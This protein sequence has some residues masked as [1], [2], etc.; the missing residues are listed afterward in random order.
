MDSRLSPQT[1]KTVMTRIETGKCR[2][3]EHQTS[4]CRTIG[5][6]HSCIHMHTEHLNPRCL[7]RSMDLNRILL[8][9]CTTSQHSRSR[10]ARGRGLKCQDRA[11]EKNDI[12]WNRVGQLMCDLQ[13]SPQA[14]V[15][16]DGRRS[17]G[18][19]NQ[20]IIYT[21][22]V[23]CC[24]AFISKHHGNSLNLRPRLPTPFHHHHQISPSLFQRPASLPVSCS[25]AREC[26]QPPS[27][28][29]SRRGQP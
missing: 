9:A 8:V 1:P 16:G 24:I 2:A 4:K 7:L 25:T 15:V 5:G 22:L 21:C 19:T 18:N 13:D 23:D 10:H 14:I 26:N 20:S 28:A 6:H 11:G 3:I 17:D 27:G 29:F 12:R